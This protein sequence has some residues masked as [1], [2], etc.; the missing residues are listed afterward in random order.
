MQNDRLDYFILAY[1]SPN[2]SAA[3]ARIPMSPQGFFEGHPQS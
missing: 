3:A 2:F 1:E